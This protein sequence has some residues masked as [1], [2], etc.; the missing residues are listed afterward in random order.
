MSSNNELIQQLLLLSAVRF[1]FIF[2]IVAACVGL[3]LMFFSARVFR[4]F[5]AVNH[6]VS[7]RRGLRHM[8]LARDV[9]TG[10]HGHR[11]IAGAIMMLA[12]AYSLAGLLFWFDGA[13]F[14]Y[15][16]GLGFTDKLA[17][18]LIESTRWMFLL[19]SL[20]GA[21]VGFMLMFMPAPLHRLEALVNRW[22][23]FRRASVGLDGMYAPVDRLVSAFP[24]VSGFIIVAG[25]VVVVANS[26]AL[27]L[28]VR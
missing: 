26:T 23:S 18:W 21:V 4:L 20:A 19:G 13:A 15:A 10:V 2:G 8:S 1:F 9:E 24:R 7:T 16:L 14:V 12:A 28:G 17:L 5:G 11:R 25:A 27:L 3:G 22:Y 6:Y